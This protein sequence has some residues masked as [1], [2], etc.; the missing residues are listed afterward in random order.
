MGNLTWQEGSTHIWI[1]KQELGAKPRGGDLQFCNLTSACSQNT[2]SMI[3]L[4]AS[5]ISACTL[6]S[7]AFPMMYSAY[8]LN[9]QGDN[10]QPWRTPFPIWNQLVFPCP[11]L[12]VGSWPAYRFLRRQ[13][14]WSGIPISFR[15]FYSLL[16]STQ[17]K[18]GLRQ[19][20]Y[21]TRTGQKHWKNKIH[22]TKWKENHQA[23]SKHKGRCWTDKNEYRVGPGNISTDVD[24][25]NAAS[26]RT[27][28]WDW[29]THWGQANTS[30]FLPPGQNLTLTKNVVWYYGQAEQGAGREGYPDVHS[31]SGRQRI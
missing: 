29:I 30:T 4:P 16:W 24:T 17:S 22:F 14:R 8:K 5:L 25:E 11:V 26:N 31:P 2:W 19:V 21:P 20:N 6:S 1:C 15:I 12:T 13:V 9:N 27:L 28:K 7:L 3:F 10:I 18:G 23:D